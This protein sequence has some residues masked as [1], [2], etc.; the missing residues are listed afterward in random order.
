MKYHLTLIAAALIGLSACSQEPAAPA[1]TP[2]PAPTAS[3]TQTAPASTA[4][5]A[6]AASAA[7]SA[8]VEANDT[9]KYNTAEITI[10]K[11]CPSFTVKLKNTGTLPKASM[12]HDIVI[13]RTSDAEAVISEGASAGAEQNFLKPGDTRV[14]ANTPLVGGGEEASLNLDPAKLAAGESYDFFCS[15]PGH[16]ASMRGKI[17]LV[18]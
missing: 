9:M 3:E 15:F 18:D 6:P 14:I 4:A 1:E 7:C 2:T 17:K 8:T 16:L 10:S 12:G 5:S 13:A 11:A